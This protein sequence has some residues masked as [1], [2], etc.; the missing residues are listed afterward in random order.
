MKE[1]RLL[2]ILLFIV[3]FLLLALFFYVPVI[4]VFITGFSKEGLKA[5]L[6]DSYCRRIC[7]FSLKQGA[8][9]TLLS[10]AI[11]FPGAYI[12]ARYTFRG[13]GLIKA[14]ITVPY[15]LPPIAAVLGIVLLIGNNG[16]INR[17][18]MAL[19][20][21][22]QPPLHLLYSLKAILIAHTFYNIPLFI[23]FVYP[24]WEKIP[25]SLYEAGKSL[26]AGRLRLFRTVT[27]PWLLCAFI[28]ACALIFVL[29]FMS[30]SI[31]LVLGGGPQYSTMEVEIYKLARTTSQITKACALGALESLITLLF[32]SVYTAAGHKQ[33]SCPVPVGKHGTVPAEKLSPRH[34]PVFLYIIFLILYVAMPMV[35]IAL[36]SFTGKSGWGKAGGL[37]LNWYKAFTQPVMYNPVLN[38]LFI[39]I[40][41][42]ICAIVLS[43]I[44]S[45]VISRWPKGS[46]LIQIFFFASLGIPSILLSLGFMLTISN[47]GFRPN[48]KLLLIAVHT[49]AV[50]PFTIKAISLFYSR[51]NR[52]CIECAKSLGAKPLRI[53]WTVKLPM[54]KN[55]ILTAGIFAFA[56][57]AGEVN[58]A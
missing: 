25:A 1:N 5:V 20:G 42:V 56:V 7:L 35:T 14:L 55:G 32:I 10:A 41:T 12:L 58:G 17:A 22:E 13:K 45:A 53:L 15:V 11:G 52:R 31:V 57:S 44:I 19:S 46:F 40:S 30:F 8:L 34:F 23:R 2:L 43:L 39:A 16:I 29:C 24:V 3:P 18:L 6:A 54:I 37:T 26:G 33:N 48:G 28:A 38:T 27:C 47:L 49:A 50:L 4:T 9:S 36:N 51:I 21:A